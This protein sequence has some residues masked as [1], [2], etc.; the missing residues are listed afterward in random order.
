MH[1][2]NLAE[3]GGAVSGPGVGEGGTAAVIV[4][5]GA[6][7]GLLYI[8]WVGSIITAPD[9]TVLLAAVTSARPRPSA[10]S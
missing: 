3:V 2:C 8:R 10:T 7:L 5:D 4:R 6:T 1:R 9:S